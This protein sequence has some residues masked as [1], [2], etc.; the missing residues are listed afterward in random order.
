MIVE[1][2]EVKAVT[3]TVDNLNHRPYDTK[4]TYSLLQDG[5]VVRSETVS[6]NSEVPFDFASV[7]S[8][9]YTLAYSTV[10][11]GIK[12]EGKTDIVI[13]DINEKRLPFKAKY[14]Y[15][16]IVTENGIDFIL[17]TTR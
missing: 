3:F 12:V 14:F 5:K 13:F 9:K 1:K 11:R 17:G 6:S 4:V 16:P 10:Y 2:N 8:G 15:Y 7:K